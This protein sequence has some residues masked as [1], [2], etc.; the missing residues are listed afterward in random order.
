MQRF[1]S[2][3]GKYPIL[4]QS[5]LVSGSPIDLT[6]SFDWKERRFRILLDTDIQSEDSFKRIGWIELTALRCSRLGPPCLAKRLSYARSMSS[7]SVR[8]GSKG[9][10]AGHSVLRSNSRR[11]R[12]VS[13][14]HDKL[15]QNQLG[16]LCR[17]C[18]CRLA[19]GSGEE[20][21]VGS[22][23]THSCRFRLRG[24]IGVVYKGNK[25]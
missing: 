5:W 3:S 13:D 21:V 12:G 8:S 19:M 22:A 24:G 14:C 9:V 16:V 20:S 7:L 23:S 1:S 11:V 2:S 18:F 10:V 17:C 15:S 25:S 4:F 6:T